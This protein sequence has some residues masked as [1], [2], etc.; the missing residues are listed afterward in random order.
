MNVKR[1]TTR[2]H[3]R[4]ARQKKIEKQAGEKSVQKKIGEKSVPKI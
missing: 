1:Q 4:T 3:A 2:A